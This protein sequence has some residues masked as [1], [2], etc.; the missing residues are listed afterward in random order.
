MVLV[1]FRILNTGVLV[2]CV[3]YDQ[4]DSMFLFMVFNLWIGQG[5]IFE[6]CS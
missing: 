4:S 6:P 1:V 3:V 5:F 2:F